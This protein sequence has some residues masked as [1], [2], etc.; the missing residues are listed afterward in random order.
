MKDDSRHFVDFF[1]IAPRH[2]EIHAELENWARW[3]SIRGA[4][5]EHPMW[6]QAK[7]NSF[8]WHAPEV[9]PKCD[10][11]AALAMEKAVSALPEKHRYAI[12]WWYVWRFG[13]LKARKAL[14]VTSQALLLLVNDGRAILCNRARKL[15]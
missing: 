1:K 9:R 3:V 2:Q 10:Q 11:K 7:S 14:G 15:G 13:E 4:S 5:W 12:R 8:Q 6:K